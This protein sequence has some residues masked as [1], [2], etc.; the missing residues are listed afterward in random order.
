MEE[1]AYRLPTEDMLPFERHD[2]Y[3]FHCH[4]GGEVNRDFAQ[5]AE[6][7]PPPSTPGKAGINHLNDEIS[8]V[9]DPDPYWI[10]DDGSGSG[11]GSG[12][13]FGIRIRIQEGKNDPQMT[14]VEKIGKFHVLNCWMFSFES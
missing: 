5:G 6:H 11:S 2:W 10:L 8:W 13:V 4:A 12:S 9:A 14:K 7:P 3:C 1:D